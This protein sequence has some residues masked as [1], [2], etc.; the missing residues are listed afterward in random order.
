MTSGASLWT[1]G[2]KPWQGWHEEPHN[3]KDCDCYSD[4]RGIKQPC[5]MRLRKASSQK[6]CPEIPRVLRRS[7]LDRS[8]DEAKEG[9]RV[10]GLGGINYSINRGHLSR[11]LKHNVGKQADLF[12]FLFKTQ[13]QVAQAGL[14][15]AM[16]VAKNDPETLMPLPPPLKF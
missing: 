13:S 5:P 10:Q 8:S 11:Q 3:D 15:L 4:G 12:Y 9:D 2:D 16:Y 7:R 1:A 6:G 14:R